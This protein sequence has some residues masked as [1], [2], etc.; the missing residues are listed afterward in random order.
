MLLVLNFSAHYLRKLLLLV[1]LSVSL[2]AAGQSFSFSFQ[3]AQLSTVFTQIEQRSDYQFIYTEELLARSAP[4]SFTV[5]NVSIDSVLKLCFKQQPLDYTMEG[6]H[7]VVRKKVIEKPV[8][9]FRELRGKVVDEQGEPAPGI[10]LVIKYTSLMAASD[11]NGEFVFFNAPMNVILLVSGVGTVSQELAVGTQPYILVTVRAKVAILDET[12]VIAYG[13]TTKRTS[14]GTVQKV[15]K[16]ELENQPITNVLAGM[17][18]RVTGL[19]ITQTSGLPGSNFNIRLRGQNSIANGN[20]PLYIIDGVPFPSV[21]LTSSMGGGGGANSSPLSGINPNDIESIEILK[22]ADA[23]AIYGSRGANGVILITT[24]KAKSTQTSVEA[25]LFTGWGKV[26]RFLP[27]LGLND[28]LTMRREAFRNDGVVPTTANARDLMLWDTTRYTDWQRYLIGNTMRT[29]DVN[30]GVSGGTGL[31]QISLNAGYHKESTI[32]PGDFG[33]DKKSLRLSMLHTSANRRFRISLSGS[34]M[35]NNTILPKEDMASYISLA[36]NAPPIYTSDG[37]FNWENSTWTNPMA[38]LRR[39]YKTN[40]SNLI[41]NL[42]LSYNFFKGLDGRVNLGYSSIHMDE[43]VTIPSISQDP[44]LFRIVAA[45]FGN[46]Q[47][48][49][50]IAEPQLSYKRNIAKGTIQLLTGTTFQGTDQQALV[51][52][53]SGY[54]SDELLGSIQSAST[55]IVSTDM[56]SKYRYGGFFTRISFDWNNKYYLTLNGRRDGSS[57]Y[58]PDNRFANFGS[59]GAGWIFSKEK[60]LASSKV[61]SY[62][63]LKFSAGVTGNDQIGDYKYLDSYG[64]YLYSYQ[65]IS[66]LV[67]VQL[68]NPSYSWEK[69][70]KNEASL[71]LGFVKDRVLLTVNYYNNFTTN[72]LVQYALPAITGFQGILKNLPAC[73]RNYGW[74]I[75]LNSIILQ[76]KDWQLTSKLS[77]TI[78]RNKL[79]AFDGLSSSSFANIY[80]VGMPLSISKRFTYT[81]VDK[82]TG[83]YT[84]L[85]VNRDG[86]ISSPADISSVVFVGQQFFGGF[87]TNVSFKN[88]SAGFFAQF[89]QIKHTSTYAAQFTK[90]GAAMA[91]Q[92]AYV[93]DRWQ[94]PGQSTNVQ[95]F[96]VSN[97]T[98]NTAFTNF[99]RSDMILGDGSYIRVKN[100]YGNYE[101]PPKFCSKIGLKTFTAF[102]QLQN[103]FTITQYKGLD[104][105]TKSVIPPLKIFTAGFRLTL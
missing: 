10:T 91:N 62:G 22:D 48:E 69:V 100:I 31:T 29:T 9:Q 23:T 61:L 71:E 17:E 8:S 11:S 38:V 77:I 72:Q 94:A 56:K 40:S 42:S 52:S 102:I 74:E 1:F 98:S 33:E 28:Y 63:K 85:D 82:T 36:P 39:E 104:P 21:T 41:S 55:V 81:G 47:I 67:P 79:L 73:I 18:G 5:S 34:Y 92:P 84:F 3:R 50:F 86:R 57:R 65:G 88:F 53:G 95:K 46:N 32:L 6:K 35:K 26:T 80:V 64:N 87:E 83:N 59:V 89:V 75:E 13:K 25:K 15:S 24:K 54:Q 4:V 90:P 44:N 30:I 49:T 76:K 19:Q 99:R 101:L 60:L 97:S 43:H 12:I 105:E 14:T 45:G 78:P 93:L 68:F 7:I 20:D 27:L 51:L 103:P 2:C 96:S 37:K 16:E 70:T 66:T 58:G